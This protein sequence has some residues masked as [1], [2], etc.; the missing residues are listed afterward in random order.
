MFSLSKGG[1]YCFCCS[2]VA[3]VS[4]PLELVLLLVAFFKKTWTPTCY[5]LWNGDPKMICAAH[6]TGHL[7]HF[8]ATENSIFWNLWILNLWIL[9]WQGND[10]KHEESFPFQLIILMCSIDFFANNYWIGKLRFRSHVCLPRRMP[11]SWVARV[12]NDVKLVS[13]ASLARQI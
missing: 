11:S 5:C 6:R 9:H 1:W 10:R 4:C 8:Y 3:I 7:L 13:P 12:T 2:Q